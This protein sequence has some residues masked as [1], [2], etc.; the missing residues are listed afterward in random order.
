MEVQLRPAQRR[1][2]RRLR[3]Q[4]GRRPHGGHTVKVRHRPLQT[5]DVVSLRMK[6]LITAQR[7]VRSTYCQLYQLL[8][9]RLERYVQAVSCIGLITSRSNII[10]INY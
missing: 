1:A 6:S 3:R 2:G 10:I 5:K 8:L 4:L 9:P 7:F